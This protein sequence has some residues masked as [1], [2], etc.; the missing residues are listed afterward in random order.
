[1]KSNLTTLKT[2]TTGELS[3][4]EAVRLAQEGDSEGFEHL[5]QLHSRRVYGLCLRMVKNPIEA[6]DLTQDAFLQTFRKI[7]TFRG[8]SLFSTWLY[9]LTVNI[10]L[11]GFR[12]RKHSEISVDETLEPNDDSQALCGN[13]WV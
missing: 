8:D 5:Y 3:E 2:S 13:Q 9:R 10:V 11:M 1:M 4:S 12:K 6:E 7:Q